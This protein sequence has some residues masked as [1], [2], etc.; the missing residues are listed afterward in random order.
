MPFAGQD[1]AGR[2][3]AAEV[4]CGAQG[5]EVEGDGLGWVAGAE[6]VVG[7]GEWGHNLSYML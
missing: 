2:D 7:L 4:R 6:V 5:L 3:N 1:D